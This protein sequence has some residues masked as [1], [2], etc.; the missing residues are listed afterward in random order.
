MSHQFRH[1]LASHAAG[2]VLGYRQDGR[3]IYAIAG[4]SDG[5][6]TPAAPAAPA[7]AA[8]SPAA[9]AAP[10]PAAPQAPAPT[11]QATTAPATP[12]GEPQDVASLPDWAQTLIRSTRAEAADWRTR[13]QGTAPTPAAPP[14]PEP[15]AAEGDIGR[16]PK[17]AQQQI[18]QAA[19]AARSAT[20]QRAVITVAPAAGADIAR[21][22]DS[23][24]AM[25]A[26]AQVDPNDQAAV[27][28][29]IEATLT[30]HPH[31]AATL[32]GPARGGSDFSRQTPP[33]QPASLSEA[34]AARLG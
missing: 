14:A 12:P 3:P 29:A 1:P 9:P 33:P 15:P 5:G 28:A 6:S 13:A 32:T 22:L 18:T 11:P 17:W 30:T 10:A 19:E 21:V 16:L 31:L 27:K 4:G 34:I 2:T 8:G 23:Q 25:T 24:S 26:L 20:I 7:P